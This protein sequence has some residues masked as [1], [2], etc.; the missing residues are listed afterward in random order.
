MFLLF[1]TKG[2]TNSRFCHYVLF[3]KCTFLRFLHMTDEVNSS[4]CNHYISSFFGGK[5]LRIKNN[6][7]GPIIQLWGI[8]AEH[9]FAFWNFV[10]VSFG[11]C[12]CARPRH[13]CESSKSPSFAP[14]NRN[15]SLASLAGSH[16]PTSSSEWSDETSETL[17][18]CGR[19]GLTSE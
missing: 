12:Y 10:P 14:S 2:R 17:L 16:P 9:W 11:V 3:K 6:S 1:R 19:K 4:L 13:A 5:Y 8:K 15:H 18:G 7:R